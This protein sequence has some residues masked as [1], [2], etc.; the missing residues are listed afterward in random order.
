MANS[1]SAGTGT[2]GDDP[3]VEM[4]APDAA[5]TATGYA[6]GSIGNV[7]PGLDILGLAVE[8]AGDTVTV[9][10]S[11]SAG[12]AINEPGHPSLPRDPDRHS[13]AI[14]AA[15][16]L[17]SAGYR[18]SRGLV[19][20]V[21]KGL[22]LAGGQGGSAASAIAAAV[23]TNR[24][25][26]DPLD[27]T[28]LLEAGLEAETAV[29][30]RHL[31]N[32]APSLLGGLVLIRGLHPIDV[33]R[34]PVPAGLRLVLVHPALEM[35]T[36]EGR[37]VLPAAVD[38]ELALT[39]AANVAAMVLG[40]ATGDLALLCRAVDDRIAEPARA[41]LL[42]GFRAAQRA[43]RDA[44]AAACSIS[45]SGPTVFALTDSDASARAIAA[46]MVAA[47]RAEAIAATSRIAQVD[48]AGARII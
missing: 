12:M 21:S 2:S 16:V 11:A 25:L 38:R 30:G 20:S 27:Q 37:A 43:A 26:G 9:A 42:P 32:L 36:C 35:R 23:A 40:A 3:R 1:G 46:A 14:A 28:R 45:G 47:Y 29:A 4:V 22:P 41:P 33:V 24:L 6:P 15:A 8:G 31:D 34:V 18:G 7:G 39:Q 5:G 10:W 19:L 13:A 44:G 17:R 48:L